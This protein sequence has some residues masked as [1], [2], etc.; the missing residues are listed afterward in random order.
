[1]TVLIY[2][3][4][5]EKSLP[6]ADAILVLGASQINGTPSPVFKAR[7]DQALELY[8]QGKAPKIMLTG[9]VGQGKTTSEAEAGRQYLAQKGVDWAAVLQEDTGTTTWQS[10]QN[11]T[12][13]AKQHTIKKIII[14]SD[15]FH[16]FRSK[17]MA[18]DLGFTAYTAPAVTS[19]IAQHKLTELRYVLRENLVF[20]LYILFSV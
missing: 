17:K 16:L 11:I 2:H 5:R 20:T 18:Q 14:V 13:V 10:L 7:L 15:G 4:A 6:D 1:L 12:H 19:P 8:H 9:G 3:T